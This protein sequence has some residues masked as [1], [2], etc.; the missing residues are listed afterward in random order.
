MR[1]WLLAFPA[2]LFACGESFDPPSL[3]GGLRVLAIQADPPEIAASEEGLPSQSRIRTLLADPA[4]LDD[5]ARKA[6]VAYVSCT[7]DPSS[8]EPNLCTAIPTLRD[9]SALGGH[10]GKGMCDA[11]GGGGGPSPGP[12]IAFLGAETCDQAQG[13]HPLVVR[14][15]E[16]DLPLPAPVVQLPSSIDLASLPQGHPSR[17]KGIQVVVLAMAIQASPEEIAEAADPS[18]PCTLAS[19]L[20]SRFFELYG[21]REHV[22]ALKR[23]QVRG[24]DA[25][26]EPNVNPSIA[27]ILSSGAPLPLEP[28]DPW[29]DA[30]TFRPGSS[31]RLHPRPPAPPVDEDGVQLPLE[32]LYQSFTRLRADGTEVGVEREHWAYSWF[33]TAGALDATMTHEPGKVVVWEA[34]RG[35]GVPTSRRAF[36]Y[37][38]VRDGRGGIDWVVREGR[39]N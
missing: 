23:V 12:T 28:G 29:P 24:P 10:L 4:Q 8:S 20:M 30:A 17:K 34:P 31:H 14:V 25:I 2:L 36:F 26:D 19:S 37:V 18:D 3:V 21:E 9:P 38:V 35:D 6:L 7:P 33:A 1:K 32:T 22:T 13:C 5:P 11:G 27:G 39:I 16:V 15:G